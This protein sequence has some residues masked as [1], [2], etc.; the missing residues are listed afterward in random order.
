MLALCGTPYLYTLGGAPY[1]CRSLILHPTDLIQ[2]P[3]AQRWANASSSSP[4]SL[5]SLNR[6][7]LFD[8][9]MWLLLLMA[10]RGTNQGDNHRDQ[11]SSPARTRYRGLLAPLRPPIHEGEGESSANDVV[12]DGK[13]ARADT[14]D[15]ATQDTTATASSLDGSETEPDAESNPEV[16][17]QSSPATSYVSPVMLTHFGIDQPPNEPLYMLTAAEGRLD[18]LEACLRGMEAILLLAND[19]SA[20]E[21]DTSCTEAGDGDTSCTEAGLDESSETEYGDM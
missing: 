20:D 3:F 14:Q 8:A 10:V 5:R 1:S 7:S 17:D 2:V 16:L 4:E 12:D 11:R 6:R 18:V 19:A 13:W 9:T 21:M 15:A